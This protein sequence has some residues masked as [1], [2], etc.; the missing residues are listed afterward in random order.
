MRNGWMDR[1]TDGWAERTDRQG[2]G[3]TDGRTDEWMDR[4]IILYLHFVKYTPFIYTGIPQFLKVI[5]STRTINKVEL[6]E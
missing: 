6:N 1:Q 4:W 2:N 5:Y 3:L